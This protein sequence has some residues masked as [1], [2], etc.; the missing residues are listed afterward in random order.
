MKSIFTITSFVFALQVNTTSQIEFYNH[1]QSA[2][3]EFVNQ[4]YI[5]KAQKI[6][7]TLLSYETSSARAQFHSL[8]RE[9]WEPGLSVLENEIINE[10]LPEIESL[11]LSQKFKIDRSRTLVTLDPSSGNLIVRV[12][13]LI[14]K[15][16][17]N[18]FISEEQVV[19]QLTMSALP[20]NKIATSSFKRLE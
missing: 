15:Y 5:D 9:I 6:L 19:Y 16:K 4:V 14:T 7:E 20:Q 10:L 1:K 12:Y 18:K 17:Q 13:G 2:Y 3:A 8:R 11:Q